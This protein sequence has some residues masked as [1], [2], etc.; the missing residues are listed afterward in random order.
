MKD[1]VVSLRVLQN[2]EA[3]LSLFR[4]TT[5]FGAAHFPSHNQSICSLYAL[6]PVEEIISILERMSSDQ[7]EWYLPD[8]PRNIRHLTS[9]SKPF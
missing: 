9:Q 7:K 8:I 2:E 3:M 4:A 1:L 5:S 6:K